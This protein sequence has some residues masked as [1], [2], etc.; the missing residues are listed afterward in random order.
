M[1]TDSWQNV[2][3]F[4]SFDYAHSWYERT[5]GGH[6]NS[7]KISQVNSFFTQGREYFRN[8]DLA[9]L[10]VKP[11]LLYYGVLSLSRG[12]I[13]LKDQDKKE[14]SLGQTHGLKIDDWTTTLKDG[15]RDIL[16]LKIKA[17]KGT[18]RELASCCTNQHQEHCFRVP[19]ND[20]IGVDHF[21]G[22]VR[23]ASDE[24]ALT[25]GD[26]LSRLMNT[27][28]EYRRI[29]GRP[30]KWFPAV[31]TTHPS[32]THFAFFTIGSL[33]NLGH[34][35]NLLP[36]GPNTRLEFG[37]IA[38]LNLPGNL[39]FPILKFTHMPSNKHVESF[40]VFH[41]RD[42]APA[43]SVILNFPNGDKLSEFFKLYLV[44]YVLGMLVRYY[45]SKWMSLLRG[46][47]GDFAKPLLFKAIEAIGTSFPEELRKQVPGHSTT[48]E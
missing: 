31:V 8:A 35:L 32:E 11:L 40:P 6:P 45:P 17:T 43:M 48:I 10:S 47:R 33:D 36:H 7:A 3:L 24:S 21:L 28:G 20:L 2:S 22:E 19:N 16:G 46:G 14:E 29:T 13:L 30:G 41:Y 12:V 44:S 42:G 15:I 25:L 4:E 26:L 9:D 1:A 23:F 37:S 27:A 18:F 34:N 39:K 5:H 38:G